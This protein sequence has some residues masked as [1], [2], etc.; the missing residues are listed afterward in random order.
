MTDLERALR[1]EILSLITQVVA[2][3][4][5]LRAPLKRI[6]RILEG[7]EKEERRPDGR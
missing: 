4:P 6:T 2:E 3:R 1:H 5:S 7:D